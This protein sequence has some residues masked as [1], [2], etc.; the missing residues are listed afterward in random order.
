MSDI[1]HALIGLK[2][3][4]V[5]CSSI[6]YQSNENSPIGMTARANIRDT[7]SGLYNLSLSQP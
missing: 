3:I 4:Y 1:F 2:K 6:E 7:V 5:I